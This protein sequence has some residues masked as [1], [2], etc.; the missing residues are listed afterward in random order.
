MIRKYRLLALISMIIIFFVSGGCASAQ[1][2]HKTSTTNMSNYQK[3]L[4][5]SQL[6]GKQQQAILKNLTVSTYDSPASDGLGRSNYQQMVKLSDAV[7]QGVVTNWITLPSENNQP[8]F[9]ILQVNIN[10]SLVKKSHNLV[11]KSIY[12]YQVGGL[13]GKQKIIAQLN[14]NKWSNTLSAQQRR[15]V[16]LFEKEGLPIPT[17]G[18]QVVLDLNKVSQKDFPQMKGVI[19]A[20]N[21]YNLVWEEQSLWLKDKQTGK[22]QLANSDFIKKL[23]NTDFQQQRKASGRGPYEPAQAEQLQINQKITQQINQKI[24]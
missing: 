22:Y 11:G 16:S 2:A 23:A 12:Y 4:K 19:P 1:Q 21:I 9:T 5:Q 20:K 7:V 17:I 18:T 13:Q 24:Q 6:K 8:P 3:T 14:K 15:Q 10:R